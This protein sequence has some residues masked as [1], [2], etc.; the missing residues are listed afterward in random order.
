MNKGGRLPLL[1][2]RL[3][4]RLCRIAELRGHQFFA[5]CVLSAGAVLFEGVTL[6]LL[7]PLLKGILE[8]DFGFLFESRV[9]SAAKVLF[10]FSIDKT[11]QSV[12]MIFLVS[13]V[14]LTAVLKNLLQ[15]ASLVL[16]DR[17]LCDSI[18]RIRLKLFSRII[19]SSKSRLD[20]LNQGTL[21]NTISS[22]VLETAVSM[23]ALFRSLCSGLL[24]F[25][26]LA[27]MIYISL[28][29][30]LLTLFMA[31]LFMR[32]I[33]GLIRRIKERSKVYS[34]M[35]ADW[36]SRTSNVLMNLGL[37]K[38]FRTEDA[39]EKRFEAGSLQSA[40]A[41]FSMEKKQEL[42]PVI[43]ELGALFALLVMMCL[44]ALF[45]QTKAEQDIAKLLIFF[46]TLRRALSNFGAL[47]HIRAHISRMMGPM[48][49]VEEILSQESAWGEVQGSVDAVDFQHALELRGVEL[50][51][52]GG[53]KALAGI[54]LKFEKGRMTALVGSSGAGKTSVVNLLLRL[55][56]PQA[57][58][59]LMDGR[60]IRTLTLDA[61]RKCFAIVSQETLLFNDT[62]RNNILYGADKS[63]SEKD[64]ANVILKSR[65][66]DLIQTLPQGLETV[67]GDKGVRLSGGERQRLA[68]A[69]AILRGSPILI[70]DEATSA[71]DS[72]TEKKIQ[73]A[74]EEAAAEK[75]LIVIAHRFS[76]VKKADKIIVLEKGRV[77]EQGAFG[78]L[79][80]KKDF[81]YRYWTEQ[82]FAD[83]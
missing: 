43:Y 65:L 15:Y 46:F 45:L 57:G 60:D 68:I 76:T 51:Y 44:A 21:L 64:L 19:H 82:S 14:F 55:Y 2:W 36:V 72:V 39:E 33:S 41:R 75:T 77:V 79:L 17:I 20:E 83:A 10:G 9:F 47:G 3:L 35:N 18:H 5:A 38:A 48:S 23:K 59:I 80:S 12:L 26:Y 31:P 8:S 53:K 66:E 29:L 30:T 16:A 7:M 37:V 22:A 58:S 42:V 78:E 6:G 63:V 61:L 56:E 70:F 25:P 67:I 28:P 4:Q 27:V 62:I 11:P 74:I 13:A 34:K 71:L 81:F 32:T 73:E 49:E 24:I 1:E 40:R 52:K 69:R 54:D 50:T